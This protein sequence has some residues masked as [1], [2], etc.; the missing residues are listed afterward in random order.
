LIS[1]AELIKRHQLRN[2]ITRVEEVDH[3]LDLSHGLYVPAD[4]DLLPSPANT[5]RRQAWDRALRQMQTLGP[6]VMETKLNAIVGEVTW[7]GTDDELDDDLVT[8]NIRS[9]AQG[10]AH[11][12]IVTG[13]TGGYAHNDERGLAR[14][15]RLGGYLEPYTSPDN[16]DEITG[17][18]QAWQVTRENID[19]TQNAFEDNSRTRRYLSRWMVRVYDWSESPDGECVMR[20]WENL[21]DPTKL[22]GEP[23][24]TNDAHPRPRYRIRTLS[25][26]GLPIGEILMAMPQ[27]KALWATE[28]RLVLSEELAAFPML[29]AFGPVNTGN[30]DGSDA[31]TVGASEV[32]TGGSEATLEWMQ[33]GNLEELRLQRTLRLERI[34]DDLALPGGF[35]GRDSPS[36][37]A[38]TEANVRFRQNSDGYARDVSGLLT[39]LVKDYALLTGAQPATVA[40]IPSQAY[41][42]TSRITAILQLYQAGLLPLGVAAT[43]IQPFYPQWSDDELA[44]WVSEQTARVSVSDF[45]A[46]AGA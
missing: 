45:D 39:E 15:S 21:T 34:R 33:P 37:E 14:I 7:G 36:G 18:Y 2:L 17:L 9:L 43:A 32:W 31:P 12:Y 28:A 42:E 25:Q 29:K 19:R 1:I 46:L 6:R 38:L 30:D 40:V 24:E 5:S 16:V 23:D 20:Q 3:A 13:I 41:D 11:Q 35:L 10:L 44:E 4:G 26:D 27:M 22:A 8:L